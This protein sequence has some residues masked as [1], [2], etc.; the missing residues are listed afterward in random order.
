MGER[1]T[2]VVVG[3]GIGGLSAALAIA[4]AGF[5]AVVVERSAELLEIGAGIQLSPNAG[6]V[7]AGFGL[8]DAIA[9]AA[10]EPAF[11]DIRNGLTGAP[12]LA[13][14]GP[15]FAERGGFPYRVIHRA[16]LQ[17]ILAASAGRRAEITLLLG[18][19]V[20]DV[21][22]REDLLFVRA[23]RSEGSDVVAAAAIIGADG[24]WSETRARLSGAPDAR[25]SG[26]TAWRTVIPLDNAPPGL[27]ADRV[28]LW[29][30]PGA[31]LVHYPVAQ[32]A[33]INVVA[34]VE[35]A[36][37]RIGWATHAAYRQIAE[38][39]GGWCAA[40]RALVSGPSPW[41]KFAIHTVDPTGPWVQ[42]RIALLGDAAHAMVPFL[43]QGAAMA[44]EDAAVLG[45]C[46]KTI[47]DLPAALAAFEAERKPRV[48]RVWRAARRTG[49]H[50]HWTGLLAALRDLALGAAGPDLVLRRNDWIYRWRLPEA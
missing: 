11:I 10:I 6:R 31:H 36:F 41:Q 23:K 15:A 26:R 19:R 24:V 50:Y 16:E 25:P 33:A 9:A 43:A 29:L 5:R 44:I 7:L 14:P 3:A 45:R 48:L 13:I 1:Q 35:E 42:G 39:L 47:G 46:L 28:G 22:P 38:R 8:D 40:V 17:R 30:G 34:I 18:A 49:E 37:D 21:L 4:K 2:I 32:G 27:A 20:E 12:I